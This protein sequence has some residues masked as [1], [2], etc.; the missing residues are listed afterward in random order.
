[1]RPTAATIRPGS[2]WT[3]A[4]HRALLCLSSCSRGR[5]RA[6]CLPLTRGRREWFFDEKFYIFIH[7]GIFSVPSY[8]PLGQ[9]SEWYLQVRSSGARLRVGLAARLA[10]QRLRAAVPARGPA[11]VRQLPEEELRE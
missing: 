11:E 2:R 6:A 10:D 4:Q 8:A 7:W 5:L 9:A 3:R 1:M